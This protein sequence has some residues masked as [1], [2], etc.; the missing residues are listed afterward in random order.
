MIIVE[1]LRVQVSAWL[2]T[3]PSSSCPLDLAPCNP[4]LRKLTFQELKKQYPQLILET[5]DAPP[6]NGGGSTGRCIRVSCLSEEEKRKR[7]QD[8]FSQLEQDFEKT[9]GFSRVI[10]LL[11]DSKKLLLGHNPLLDL[12][13]TMHKFHKDLPSNLDAFKR[14]LHEL[15]PRIID[16]KE[17]AALEEFRQVLNSTVLTDVF[18]RCKNE[19]FESP[20]IEL[21]P[22]FSRYAPT[23]QDFPHEAGFDAFITGYIFQ[24][25][26]LYLIRKQADVSYTEK[27][28]DPDSQAIKSHLAQVENI[29]HITRSDGSLKLVGRSQ[30]RQDRLGVFHVSFLPETTRS[31]ISA[32]FQAFGPNQI[33]WI[34]NTSSFVRVTDPSKVLLCIT[35]LCNKPAIGPLEFRVMPFVQYE[36][37][38]LA[39]YGA[40]HAHEDA[41][42]SPGSPYN[43]QK[44][45]FSET[46]ES[47]RTPSKRVRGDTLPNP[48]SSNPTD[49]PRDDTD[50]EDSSST[51]NPS[52]CSIL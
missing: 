36:Q 42:R 45:L 50:S 17:I 30:F 2:S 19:P 3:G 51:S 24:A 12:M 11:S 39:E 8:K 5:I 27:I 7:E 29:L 41:F 22:E 33:I 18:S 28:V 35:E 40:Q 48:R 49:N 32:L 6:K 16:T 25:M 46:S 21:P 14:E 38:F 37:R 44:R 47:E 20:A 26:S 31:D 52:R 10:R 13:H 23:N 9:V 15:Y 34:D 4:Y 1:Q 43:K